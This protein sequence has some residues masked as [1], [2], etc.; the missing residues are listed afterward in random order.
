MAGPGL[1]EVLCPTQRWGAAET[2]PLDCTGQNQGPARGPWPWERLCALG[3]SLRAGGDWGWHWEAMGRW[4]WGGDWGV[5]Q[6]R[7]VLLQG[8]ERVKGRGK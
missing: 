1:E 2:L 5:P 8:G 4:S 7:T 3:G 6:K